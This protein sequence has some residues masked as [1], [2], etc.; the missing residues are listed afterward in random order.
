MKAYVISLVLGLL[1][2]AFYALVKVRSPAPPILA[3]VGLLGMVIG[4]ELVPLAIHAL[5]GR[6]GAPPQ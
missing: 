4:E 5:S 3:L 6:A 1:V 2:G